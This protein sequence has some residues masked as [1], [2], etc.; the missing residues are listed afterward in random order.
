M[1]EEMKIRGLKIIC[2]EDN[3]KIKQSYIITNIKRMEEILTTILERTT[4]YKT[5][6]T[7]KSLLKEWKSHNRLYKI[8]LFRKHTSDCD[9]ESNQKLFYKI[10]Y[11]ILGI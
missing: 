3:I 9:L 11:F 4:I 5:K 1:K 8:H 6:R 10:A 2:N 7:L